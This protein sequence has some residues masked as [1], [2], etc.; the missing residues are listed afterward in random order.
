[1]LASGGDLKDISKDPHIDR[2]FDK[3]DSDI[4]SFNNLYGKFNVLILLSVAFF[5]FSH[6]FTAFLPHKK[7]GVQW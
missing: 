6:H 7:H 3:H 2:W 4:S 5:S 1:M